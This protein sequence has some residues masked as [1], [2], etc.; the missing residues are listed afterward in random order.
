MFIILITGIHIRTKINNG[1]DK[2]ISMIDALNNCN[3]EKAVT[4]LEISTTIDSICNDIT[5]HKKSIINDTSAKLAKATTPLERSA[6]AIIDEQ[7]LLHLFHVEYKSYENARVNEQCAKARLSLATSEL[8]VA[9]I[10]VEYVL[11]LIRDKK[12]DAII[13]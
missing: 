5:K 9:A 12:L 6:D 1:V 10:K 11:K 4:F 2:V 8:N 13:N 7:G 3:T